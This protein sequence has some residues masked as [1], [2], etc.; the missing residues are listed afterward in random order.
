MEFVETSW[1]QSCKSLNCHENKKS[2]KERIQPEKKVE[3]PNN[4]DNIR[5]ISHLPRLPH[6]PRMAYLGASGE[7]ELPTFSWET[8]QQNEHRIDVSSDSWA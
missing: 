3:K 5:M 4:L 2:N 8:F 1:C 7:T 6:L